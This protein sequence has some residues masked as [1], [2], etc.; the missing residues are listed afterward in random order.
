MRIISGTIKSTPKQWLPILPPSIHCKT[1]G[2]REW[3]K[4]AENQSLAIHQDIT[5]NGSLRLKFRKPPHINMRELIENC[6]DGLAEEKLEWEKSNLDTHNLVQILGNPVPGYELS[7]RDWVVLNLLCIG[8][9]HC[10]ELLY[11]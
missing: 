7:R 6:Y 5:H 4:Y 2:H 8:H 10:K 9:R 11:K 3:I 1:A